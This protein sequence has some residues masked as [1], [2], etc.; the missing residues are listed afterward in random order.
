MAI[1][2]KRNDTKDTISYTMTYADG[3]PVNLTGA[4]VRFVM[5]KGKTLIT[6]ATAT[7]ISAATGKVEYTLNES[8][9]LLAGNYNA[10][11]EVTFSDGKIKTFPSDGYISLRIQPNVDNDQSTY[12]EDQIAYRVS[13]IQILKNEI[14]AQ[15]DQF[16]KGDSSAEVAQ[17]RVESDGTVNTTLKARLDK[18][19]TKFTQ[20]IQT[21]SSSLA[22]NANVFSTKK[23]NMPSKKQQRAMFTIIDDDGHRATL[24][25]L[26]PLLD[27]KGIVACAAIVVDY[28]NN[29][30]DYMKSAEV[31]QL[32]NAGWEIMSHSYNHIHLADQTESAIDFNLQ[33]SY[34][35]LNQLGFE[36][37]GMVYPFGSTNPYI[38]EKT[39]QIY[40]YAFGG[41]YDT[42]RGYL[43][44]SKIYRVVIGD[45]DTRTL[46]YFKEFIDRAVKEKSW[47]VLN[48]HANTISDTQWQN[49]IGMIDYALTQ[50]I[51]IVTASEA[52]EVFENQFEL[53]NEYSNEYFIVGSNG[54]A[55]SNGIFRNYQVNKDNTGV[56]VTTPL[57]SF[58][59][60]QVT[61]NAFKNAEAAA[62]FPTAE[63]VL[64]TYR[65]YDDG[66]SL[67]YQRWYPAD[68]SAIYIRRWA[69]S[70]SEWLPFNKFLSGLTIPKRESLSIADITV[71]ANS[72][73]SKTISP[74]KFTLGSSKTY[75]ITPTSNTQGIVFTWSVNTSNAIV[76][77]FNNLTANPITF[78]FAFNISEVLSEV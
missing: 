59:K 57:K 78:S 75:V 52:F 71:S 35:T 24:N 55:F 53:Y 43:H 72:N 20:D 48:T 2:L 4:T 56:T 50:P 47:L 46:D 34:D 60:G 38:L 69:I 16:A 54:Q 11:F 36:V 7:I 25:R 15:L 51:E 6:S 66:Y 29:Q 31:M 9:T 65:H 62:G 22:Q 45:V 39:K 33:N 76:F 41:L 18:K 37:D 58:E 1:Q 70:T 12:I 17:S 23:L 67:S 28:M 21:L 63:G 49:L 64:E 19:E 73:T 74:T 61:V 42:N 14:Q 10:E 3:T 13:D 32:K 30:P 44:T 40:K 27:S 77:R 26:K 8:D 5:G 68:G